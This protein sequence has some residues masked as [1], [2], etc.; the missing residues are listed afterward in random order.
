[1]VRA[2]VIHTLGTKPEYQ[3]R[4]AITPIIRHVLEEA[5][6]KGLPTYIEASPMGLPVYRH[7]GWKEFEAAI[8]IPLPSGPTIKIVPMVTEAISK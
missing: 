8:E 3:G 7:F 2:P 5:K 1:M 6:Q 4:G